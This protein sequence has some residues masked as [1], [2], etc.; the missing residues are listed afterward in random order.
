M[1]NYTPSQG[2][3]VNG[4]VADADDMMNEL[5]IIATAINTSNAEHESRDVKNLN[6]AKAYTDTEV[7]NALKVIDGGVF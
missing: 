3:F 6:T 2:V 1:P 5:D 4:R 7:V